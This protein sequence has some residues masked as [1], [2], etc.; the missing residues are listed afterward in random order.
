MGPIGLKAFR[1]VSN[2]LPRT[3][4]A[5]IPKL[6]EPTRSRMRA[7][8]VLLVL[9][10]G[11]LAGCLDNDATGP[12]D[13]GPD[14]IYTGIAGEL[15]PP[16]S[17]SQFGE[18]VSKEMPGGGQGIW[19]HQ[20]VLFWTNG[21]EL[22]TADARD[23]QNVVILGNLTSINGARDVDVLEWQG[24][25][26]ALL[27]GGGNG[28]HIVDATDPR[29]LVLVSTTTLPSGGVHNLAA[30]P[31]TPYAY[32]SG[33]SG[34]LYRVDVLDITDP[35]APVSHSFPIPRLIG[36]TV[37]ESNGCHDISVRVDLNRAYC[38]GGGG[39]YYGLGGETFIW[40]I[41]DPLAPV[42]LSAIDDPRIKYHH[43]AFANDAG[44]VLIINDE[45]VGPFLPNVPAGA[46]NCMDA[47]IPGVGSEDQVPLAAAW[48][49]DISDETSP[50][51][52]AYVQNPSGWSGDGA[53]P[54][55]L[56]GNCG[57]HFGDIIPGHEAFV[58]GWYEGGTVLVDFTDLAAPTVLDVQP[59]QGSTWD[60]MYYDGWV[61]HASDDLLATRLV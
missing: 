46:N 12:V 47:D 37:V 45:Y 15:L 13:T 3:G 55:P 30:V 1:V 49:Y 48:I 32:S 2:S 21:G 35:A 44:T 18:T 51:Q 42:W 33:S 24:R 61:Y 26:Y 58:M 50:V 40:D 60:S 31:G 25:T 19:L 16:V 54:S 28:V 57:A 27:A 23:A 29:D 8:T 10:V 5:T 52:K 38:A 11:T 20:G 41:T 14:P 9:A 22:W 34:D 39:K 59:P 43:Q 36:T 4:T 6:L 53:P 56:E 7:I 17:F